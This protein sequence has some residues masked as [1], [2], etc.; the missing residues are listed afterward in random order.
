[1]QSRSIDQEKKKLIQDQQ[2]GVMK[3]IANKG[4]LIR[5]SAPKSSS[6]TKMFSLDNDNI[7]CVNY[8]DLTESPLGDSYSKSKTQLIKDKLRSITYSTKVG[9]WSI[10]VERNHDCSKSSKSEVTKELSLRLKESVVLILKPPGKSKP[11]KTFN[12]QNS[13]KCYYTEKD[14]VL[15]TYDEC[16]N[17]ESDHVFFYEIRTQL[18]I[19]ANDIIGVLVP[20]HMLALAKIAFPKV[21]IMAVP[22]I[23][24]ENVELPIMVPESLKFELA[25]RFVLNGPDYCS[26]LE[27]FVQKSGL[28][29]FCVHLTRLP[30]EYEFQSYRDISGVVPASCK[31]DG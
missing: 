8:V 29:K 17:S 30:N 16:I 31:L 5:T 21:T 25:E 14:A 1:M 11:A 18:S 28:E 4:L 2:L 26:A 7:L 27:K 3:S 24:L 15:P 6:R 10:A 22:E 9:L 23:K 19:S 20:E 12:G 13:R